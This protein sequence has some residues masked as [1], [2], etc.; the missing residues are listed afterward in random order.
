MRLFFSWVKHSKYQ[1]AL[2]FVVAMIM[3]TNW[4]HNT[5]LIG[6]DNLQTELYPELA[7]K[8]AFFSVWQEYQSFGLVSGLAHASDIVR[9]VFMWG[10]SFILPQQFERTFFHMLMLFIG[11]LGIMRFLSYIGYEGKKEVFA[12]IGAVFY[13]L[14]FGTIQLFALPLEAFSIFFAFLPWQIWIFFEF[15]DVRQYKHIENRLPRGKRFFLF[16]LINLIASP[17][18]YIQTDFVVYMLILAAITTGLML[19]RAFFPVMI[20]GIA[21]AV[22]IIAL[23]SFWL[24]PQIYF[25]QGSGNVVREAKSN[26]ISTDDLFYQNQEKGTF[27]NV[28][29]FE[30][31]YYD[32]VTPKQGYIFNEWKQHFSQPV[33]ALIRYLIIAIMCIG[34]LHVSRYHLP[35][36]IPLLLIAVA[37]MPS[38]YPLSEINELLRSNSTL[39][40][41]FRA[42]FTKFIVP[43]VFIATC[44]FIH[45]V[46]TISQLC[47]WAVNRW[48]KESH[49]KNSFIYALNHKSPY[50]IYNELIQHTILNHKT[51]Q[52]TPLAFTENILHHILSATAETP[53]QYR[54]K[55]EFIPRVI[56]FSVFIVILIYAMP[57]FRGHY[58]NPEMRV[59]VPDEYS[60]LMQYMKTVPT[61][62]RIALLPDYTYWGWFFHRWGYNGSGFLWYGIEQ[63][64]VSRTFD[65]WSPNSESYFW[66]IK[67]A[68]EAE[69]SKRFEQVL[70]KYNI[71]YLLL[72]YSLIPVSASIKGLQYDRLERML[73]ESTLLKQEFKK[74][75]LALYS[76]KATYPVKVWISVADSVPNIGPEIS[77]T[78]DDNAYAKHG[79]YITDSTSKYNVYYPF[80]DLT[81]QV[82]LPGKKWLLSQNND[83]FT[84]SAELEQSLMHQLEYYDLMSATESAE[85]TVLAN[86]APYSFQSPIEIDFLRDRIE[87]YFNKY[88]LQSSDVEKAVFQPCGLPVGK[89]SKKTDQNELIVSSEGGSTMCFQF[90]ALDLEQQYG[91]IVDLKA[92]NIEGRPLYFYALDRTK[93]QSFIEDR[94]YSD[95]ALFILNPKFS[96]GVGY[97]FTFQNTSYLHS[98]AINKLKELNVYYF[99]YQDIKDVH[100]V[101]RDTPAKKP[102]FSNTFSA[103][104]H[105][106]YSYEVSIPSV[107]DTTTLILHQSFSP[108]WKAYDSTNTSFIQK[109][110][111]FTGTEVG[112]SVPVNNWA[113]G[114]KLSK[115]MAGKTIT[116]VFWPQYLQYAGYVVIAVLFIGTIP[117]LRSR[118]RN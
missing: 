55:R 58:I 87:V 59:T 76:V 18:Y 85:L 104:Q 19:S 77:I 14:N 9:A 65:V 45:G 15:V 62:K 69:D 115:D 32:L 107:S 86:G 103:K 63:P 67:S 44:F 90:E 31:F 6:W 96:S 28:I 71:S 108:G 42:P 79:M 4:E 97:N 84:L 10:I 102:Q 101:L 92:T 94:L 61:Q 20:R 26:T 30:G 41:I 114:W 106:Y 13:I 72:D 53:A 22:L 70:E 91:Y 2:F 36:I 118:K 3:V 112:T 47:S 34:L 27:E 48:K 100:F 56:G 38:T 75:E 43:Y 99:P 54:P 25:L 82:R 52:F 5:S 88:N 16:L 66:E 51:T 33:V 24:M 50:E 60:E 113:N 116:L 89:N 64:V 81:T 57:A 35:F 46:G 74:G 21:A 23:N 37:L 49:I 1:L 39:N 78:N 11:G 95:D 83:E 68:I 73:K 12:F 40:Q 7:V 80:L 109:L 8:R 29:R 98:K 117:F 110:M 105:T 17:A 93:V 111:P